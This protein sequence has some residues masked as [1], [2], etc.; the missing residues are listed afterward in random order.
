M[1]AV[2]AVNP[3]DA[4]IQLVVSAVSVQMVALELR[5]IPSV[6]LVEIAVEDKP[7]EPLVH[8]HMHFEILVG[9]AQDTSVDWQPQDTL[10]DWQA[11]DTLVGFLERDTLVEIGDISSETTCSWLVAGALE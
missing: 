7:V 5:H 6:A 1:M 11:Q 3:V 9:L 2:V 8:V 4:Y 10:V